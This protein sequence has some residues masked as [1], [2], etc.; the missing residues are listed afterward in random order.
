MIGASQ[1][2]TPKKP[3]QCGGRGGLVTASGTTGKTICCK[4]FV[5][6]FHFAFPEKDN[7]NHDLFSLLAKSTP[8]RLE[9]F[10][11]SFEIGK[12]NVEGDFTMSATN[13]KGFKVRYYQAA[14]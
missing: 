2:G 9:F 4:Y 14:C 6:L 11:N 12:A 3:S 7:F 13:S 10:S 1:S 5:I 8:F